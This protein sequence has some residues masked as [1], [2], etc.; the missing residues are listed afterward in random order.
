[1][2]EKEKKEYEEYECNLLVETI[3]IKQKKLE[4]L[5][6]LYNYITN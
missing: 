3:D 2:T 6:L 1:M 4:E 5:K